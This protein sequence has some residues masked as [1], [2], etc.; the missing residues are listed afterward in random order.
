MATERVMPGNVTIWAAYPE[1]FVNLA[2]PTVADMAKAT[3]VFNISCAIEESYTLNQTGSETDDSKTICDV[4][5]VASPTFVNYEASLDGFRDKSLTD[6][7]VFNLF[8]RLFK[9]KGVP[10]VLIK[11]IG[12]ANTAP[13]AV[14][15]ILSL[16]SV[17]TDNPVDIVDDVTNIMLGA[18]F[19]PT[20]GVNI[21]YKVVA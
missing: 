2:T 21:N 13:V 15:D 6:N 19:K 4:G 11:R 20:G 1:A 9:S 10:F 8:Y 18:R 16:Y 14:G 17:E 12:K 3:M 7:G 5:D